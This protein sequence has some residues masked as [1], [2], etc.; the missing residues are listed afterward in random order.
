MEITIIGTGNI[1]IATRLLAGGHAVTLLGTSGEKVMRLTVV[2]PPNTFP[3]CQ[4]SR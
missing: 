4:G 2:D 1:G 3:R